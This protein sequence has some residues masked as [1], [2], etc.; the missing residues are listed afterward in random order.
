MSYLMG[1]DYLAYRL[2]PWLL[3]AFVLGA[4]CCLRSSVARACQAVACAA[5]AARP[6]PPL[7]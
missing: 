5:S 7:R 6:K 1:L 4:A 2:W 3:A